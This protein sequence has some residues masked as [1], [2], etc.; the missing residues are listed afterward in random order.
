M[1]VFFKFATI[2]IYSGVLYPNTISYNNFCIDGT[3]PEAVIDPLAQSQASYEASAQPPSH[4]GWILLCVFT[5][6]NFAP[7]LFGGHVFVPTK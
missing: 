4:H 6:L 2:H 5:K 3:M 1:F 7:K